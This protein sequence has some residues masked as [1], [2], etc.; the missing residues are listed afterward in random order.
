MSNKPVYQLCF[1]FYFNS[2]NLLKGSSN[3]CA[4]CEFKSSQTGI[5]V[6]R[7]LLTD[8]ELE[9]EVLFW[10]DLKPEFRAAV[11]NTVPRFDL[12]LGEYEGQK[13]RT[14]LNDV[15]CGCS[16]AEDMTTTR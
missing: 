1:L 14:F 5:A 12:K 15:K 10:F 8:G 16:K 7:L 13:S 2:V 9:W 6:G 3:S 4:N 11:F